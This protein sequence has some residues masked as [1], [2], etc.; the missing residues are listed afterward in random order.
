[1]GTCACNVEIQVLGRFWVCS[2][3]PSLPHW[4]VDDFTDVIVFREIFLDKCAG[5]NPIQR[6]V[7]LDLAAA[8]R[9]K[10]VVERDI[11]SVAENKCSPLGPVNGPTEPRARIAT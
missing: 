5:V 2:Q 11:I 7:D 6:L 9:V 8:L 4:Q 3:N 1:M 10:F